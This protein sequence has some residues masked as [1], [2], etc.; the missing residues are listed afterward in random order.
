L[1]L[2]K[3]GPRMLWLL[4]GGRPDSAGRYLSLSSLRIRYTAHFTATTVRVGV[5]LGG[6]KLGEAIYL[7]QLRDSRPADHLVRAHLTET[8]D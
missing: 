6:D 5:F 4:M 3:A 2:R 1:R 7:V 8:A